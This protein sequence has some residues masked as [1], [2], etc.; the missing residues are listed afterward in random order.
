[1]PAVSSRRACPL[2]LPTLQLARAGHDVSYVPL[3]RDGH[4]SFLVDLMLGRPSEMLPHLKRFCGLTHGTT[5]SR[6]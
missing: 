5:P 1:V 2:A 6:L 4:L 3:P